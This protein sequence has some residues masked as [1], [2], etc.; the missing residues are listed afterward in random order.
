M[1]RLVL[2]LLISCLAAVLT[3][4]AH[5]QASPVRVKVEQTGKSDTISYKTVQARTLN[6]TVSSSSAEPLNLKVK[7]AI[8]ARDIKS[9]ELYTLLQGDLPVALKPRGTEKVQS[10]TANTAAEE[11]RVG[12][13][14]KSEAFGY[15]IIGQ[16]VQVLN[17]ETVVAEYYEPAAMKESFGKAPPAPKIEKKKK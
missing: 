2:P 10:M 1:N 3:A 4:T 12:S 7:Y 5:A 16:G 8:F 17:G 15:K 11:E 6:I 13:K 14:G 9:Q